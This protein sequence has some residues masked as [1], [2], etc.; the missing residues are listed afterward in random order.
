MLDFLVESIL[1]TT[2]TST[3][4][5]LFTFYMNSPVDLSAL[6]NYVV[7]RADN[8]NR[9]CRLH[10][11][12]LYPPPFISFCDITKSSQDLVNVVLLSKVMS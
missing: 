9:V 6:S 10:S 8:Q 3:P 7:S 1:D 2:Q 5:Q 11:L 12:I 4:G